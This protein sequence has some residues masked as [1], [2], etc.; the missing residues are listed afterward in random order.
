MKT[1][2]NALFIFGCTFGF[3]QTTTIDSK[4]AEVKFN[5][6]SEETE[7][8]FKDV[9][10]SIEFNPLD[11]SKSKIH[12]IAMVKSISTKNPGRDTHLKTKPYFNVRDYA[13]ISFSST[14]IRKT[15]EGGYEALGTLQIKGFKKPVVFSMEET[16]DAFVFKTS[17]YAF[18]YGVAIKKDRELSI[19][20]IEVIL[21]K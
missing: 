13:T 20:E 15:E 12:G 2:M 9:V 4:K 14:V 1:V 17:I 6:V 5:Y 8:T 21:K 11:M 10:A 19:V 3:A 7:G 16:E 18:D